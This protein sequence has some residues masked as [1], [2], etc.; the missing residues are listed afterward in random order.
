MWFYL[1][2]NVITQ[3][4]FKALLETRHGDG[5]RVGGEEWGGDAMSLEPSL[6]LGADV[7]LSLGKYRVK[8]NLGLKFF[9]SRVAEPPGHHLLENIERNLTGGL[10]SFQGG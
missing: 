10:C 2:M 5:S 4:P 3:Y 1:L 6:H 9:F 7:H 8:F